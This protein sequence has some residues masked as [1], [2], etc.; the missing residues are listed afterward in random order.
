MAVHP[1]PLLD[2]TDS[3]GMWV[4][5]WGRQNEGVSLKGRGMMIK[6]KQETSGF[7]ICCLA[8]TKV[9]WTE[10]NQC[11]KM[12]L[13]CVTWMSSKHHRRDFKLKRARIHEN[14]HLM[15]LK[16][17]IP[18]SI[19]CLSFKCRRNKKVKRDWVDSI[20]WK[21]LFVLL[22][23]CYCSSLTALL[24]LRMKWKQC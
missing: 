13:C 23:V 8:K 1:V 24:T 12:Y 9:L 7:F 16:R 22:W 10:K 14:E 19:I 21:S 17:H 2:P 11:L 15:Y 5:D 18:H 20:T 4:R 3:K 6:G